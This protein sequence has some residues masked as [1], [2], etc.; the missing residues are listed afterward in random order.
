M[1]ING[2]AKSLATD[3]HLHADFTPYEIQSS[4]KRVNNCSLSSFSFPYFSHVI[5]LLNVGFWGFGVLGF[6]GCAAAACHTGHRPW[7]RPPSVDPG[8]Q[9]WTC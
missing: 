8:G 1:R 4:E 7:G 6:W 3:R 9:N 2:M 5:H